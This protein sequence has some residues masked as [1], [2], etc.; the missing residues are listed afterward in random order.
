VIKGDLIKEDA[1]FSKDNNYVRDAT[2]ESEMDYYRKIFESLHTNKKTPDN[3][4]LMLVA[5][6]PPKGKTFLKQF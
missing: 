2:L 4:S 5:T 3:G 6:P 1:R